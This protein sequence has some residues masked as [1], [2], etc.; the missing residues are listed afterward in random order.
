VSTNVSPGWVRAA[1]V[2]DVSDGEVVGVA[3]CDADIAL[4]NIG[5]KIYATANIC[6]H[7]LARLSDGFVDGES[8]ECPLHGGRFDIRTGKGLCDPIK[9]DLKVFRVRVLGDEIQIEM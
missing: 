4:Y 1:A 8:I 2:A 5:G 7:A 6:T 9:R 3:V